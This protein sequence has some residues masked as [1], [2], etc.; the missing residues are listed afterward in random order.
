MTKGGMQK[1]RRE[2]KEKKRRRQEEKQEGGVRAPIRSPRKAILSPGG[3]RPAASHNPAAALISSPQYEIRWDREREGPPGYHHSARPTQ[4]RHPLT[5]AS[6]QASPP[7]KHGIGGGC[8]SLCGAATRREPESGAGHQGRPVSLRGSG[9]PI[10]RRGL[11]LPEIRT[12]PVHSRS[13]P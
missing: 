11:G 7:P 3:R 2:E 1:K 4:P 8:G 10:W 12:V 6:A 5:T 13:R 9:R